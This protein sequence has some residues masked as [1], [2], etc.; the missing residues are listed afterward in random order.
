MSS[1]IARQYL[2]LQGSDHDI[3]SFNK[4]DDIPLDDLAKPQF[5]VTSEALDHPHN[6]HPSKA[7]AR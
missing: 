6:M 7:V 2:R 4:P 1:H 5:G 3:A